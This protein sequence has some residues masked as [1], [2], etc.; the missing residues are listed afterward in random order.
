MPIDMVTA[1]PNGIELTNAQRLENPI[2]AKSFTFSP[3]LFIL[4]GNAENTAG[5]SQ[6]FLQNS[7]EE[8]AA[9]LVR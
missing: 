4:K 8:L 3:D 9:V 7:R 5:K 6:T 2:S 1:S